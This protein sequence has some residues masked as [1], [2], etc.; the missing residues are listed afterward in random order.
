MKKLIL[1]PFFILV[2]STTAFAASQFQFSPDKGAVEFK[3]KGWPNLVTIKGKG[4]GVSGQLSESENKISGS[5]SFDLQTLKTG[6]ELRDDHMK[7]KYL[8]VKEFPQAKL[9][10]TDVSVPTDYSGSMDFKGTMQLHGVS[11]EVVGKAQ[12]DN[13]TDQISMTAEIPIKLKDFKIEIPSYKGITVA[14]KVTVFF[15]TEAKKIK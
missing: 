1:S 7:N 4:Q 13:G 8:Q 14:D 10:L 5:L 3:T 15:K 2:F 11:K 6:I 12:L 9:T